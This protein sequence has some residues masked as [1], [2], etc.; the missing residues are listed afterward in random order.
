MN[1]NNTNKKGFKSNAEIEKSGQLEL[2]DEML[3]RNDE[4]EN[5]VHECLCVLAEDE[6]KWDVDAIYSAIDLLK[7]MLLERFGISVRHPS[8]VTDED[9]QYYCEFHSVDCAGGE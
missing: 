8:V 5:A 2:T 3:E 6:L 1:I 7:D 4:L 9:G